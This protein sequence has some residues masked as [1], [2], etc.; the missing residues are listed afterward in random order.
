MDCYTHA[1]EPGLDFIYHVSL[2]CCAVSAT[3]QIKDKTK[4]VE[5]CAVV[6]MQWS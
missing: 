1:M 3:A 2:N 6:I 4:N 5:M